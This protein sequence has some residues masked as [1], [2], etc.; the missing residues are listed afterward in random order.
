MR[1]T[2]TSAGIPGFILQL[3]SNT[4]DASFRLARSQ[5]IMVVIE[6]VGLLRSTDY[7]VA[8]VAAEVLRSHHPNHFE[9]P[10]LKGLLEF[11][12]DEFLSHKKTEFRGELWAYKDSVICFADGQPVGGAKTFLD[13]ASALDYSDYRPTPLYAALAN[14][15][16]LDRFKDPELQFVFLDVAVDNEPAGKLVFELYKQK[17]PKTCDNFKMLCTGEMGESSNKVTLHYKTSVIHRIVPN[18][19]IQG[20]DIEYGS[21]AGGES[22][23]GETF[24]DE[25]YSVLHSQRGVLG[26]ANKGRH[27]NGSQFYITL[28]ASQWMDRHY[29]AFGQ[30]VEGT[31]VL[32]KLEAVKTYNERPIVPVKI[33]DCGIYQPS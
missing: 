3:H 22:V 17:C 8:K 15:A 26:M 33:T 9:D 25:N 12:W 29:V 18:G 27:T 23:Y 5:F 14:D 13:W 1:H 11:E 16:Y 4:L 19:W 31:Q 20:G 28:K 10:V 24:E 2:G 7:H 32:N 21:G 6:V 30:L